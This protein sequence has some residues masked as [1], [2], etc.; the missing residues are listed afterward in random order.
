M[1]VSVATGVPPPSKI[2][3]MH[4]GYR[5]RA[6]ERGRTPE[7]P[8]YFLKPLSSIGASGDP[9]RR[10]AGCELLAFEGEVALVVGRRARRVTPAQG[11]GHVGWI[12]AANDFGLYDLRYADRG[13]NVRSKG[14]DGFTPLGPAYLPAESI[15]PA[16]LQLTT[17]VNG[18]RVQDAKLGEELIFGFGDIIADLSRLMTPRAR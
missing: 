6:A 5:S 16:T 10:P 15:D 14:S 2:V 18:E 11:W 7:H 1:I 4:L 3:A 8:S 9:V 12:T 17:W 13:S